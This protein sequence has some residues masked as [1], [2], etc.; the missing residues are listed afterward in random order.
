MTVSSND[1]KQFFVY[2][3][4]RYKRLF[5]VKRANQC[6]LDYSGMYGLYNT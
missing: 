5:H 1:I 6:R 3:K 4:S 2:G